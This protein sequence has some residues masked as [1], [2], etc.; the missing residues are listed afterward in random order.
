MNDLE[1]EIDVE[2]LEAEGLDTETDLGWDIELDDR[3]WCVVCMRPVL[4]DMHDAI[5]HP[6]MMFVYDEEE[7]T[8]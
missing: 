3:Y 5:D 4:G 7:F 6:S 2:D 8:Q 1:T